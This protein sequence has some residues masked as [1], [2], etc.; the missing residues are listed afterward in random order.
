MKT[1]TNIILTLILAGIFS[2]LNAQETGVKKKYEYAICGYQKSEGESEVLKNEKSGYF[3]SSMALIHG[4]IL[5]RNNNPMAIYAII[6]LVSRPDSIVYIPHADSSGNF[7]IY[8]PPGEYTL[9]VH[10]GGYNNCKISQ[11]FVEV[12]EIRTINIRLA[13]SSSSYINIIKSNRRLG[14]FKLKRMAK[15]MNKTN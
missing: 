12:G 9:K 8:L 4:N 5:D 11:L 6:Y 2:V 3:D 10:A 14:K 7:N 13:L 1:L 15:R